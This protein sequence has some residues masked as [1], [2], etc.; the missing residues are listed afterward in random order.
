MHSLC[1]V[2]VVGKA[3][4][5]AERQGEVVHQPRLGWRSERAGRELQAV[6][7][8]RQDQGASLGQLEVL[9]ILGRHQLGRRVSA[10]P[11][12][13][14]TH[15]QPR[16]VS[17]ILGGENPSAVKHRYSPRRSPRWISSETISPCL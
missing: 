8:T 7:L 15:V 12:P 4:A 1:A 16:S 14:P 6:L 2:T 17:E 10:Q 5:G 13:Q 9:P 11:L 3:G